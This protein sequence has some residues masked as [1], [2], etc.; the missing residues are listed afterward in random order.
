MPYILNGSISF[1]STFKGVFFILLWYSLL[2]KN[3]NMIRIIKK[4]IR[5]R[6]ILKW[7]TFW[8]PELMFDLISFRIIRWKNLTER[9][10]VIHILLNFLFGRDYLKMNLKKMDVN[11]EKCIKTRLYVCI[12][13][14]IIFTSWRI[15]R[16]IGCT[17]QSA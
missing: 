9:S 1:Y 12:L 11:N 4:C 13:M 3:S 15:W 2:Q 5:I 14:L 10:N 17:F 6:S 8:I 16:C 7:F